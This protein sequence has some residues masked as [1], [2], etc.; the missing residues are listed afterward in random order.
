[1]KFSQLIVSAGVMTGL[2][3]ISASSYAQTGNNSSGSVSATG[4]VQVGNGTTPAALPP[5]RS[6]NDAP[7]PVA[8]PVV[9][10]GGIV[11]QAGVG[12]TTAYGRPGVVELGGSVG[13]TLAGDLTQFNISPTVG[14]FFAEN[15]QLSGI[16]GFN[17][18]DSGGP[19]GGASSLNVLVEPSYHLPF[20][21]SLFAFLGLGVGLGYAD[22]PGA[23]FALAPRLGM[24]IMVGRSGIL[25]PALQFVYSTSQVINTPQG[26]FIGGNTSFGFQVGYT[27]M[28]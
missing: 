15:L 22:G 12:G 8:A 20:N 1:M 23:G 7:P 13:L 6:D 26:T 21:R 16:I 10:V 25:S 5:S 4:T 2:T 18:V 27:V 11:S 14:W 9:P 24:N 19:A 17:Y 3:A 28:L